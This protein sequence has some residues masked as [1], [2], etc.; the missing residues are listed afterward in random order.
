V[1]LK[2]AIDVGYYRLNIGYG[3]GD[4][5]QVNRIV[6]EFSIGFGAAV[7]SERDRAEAVDDKSSSA[8]HDRPDSGS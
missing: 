1:S 5:Q 7:A 4:P 3:D 2:E 8:T 6:R